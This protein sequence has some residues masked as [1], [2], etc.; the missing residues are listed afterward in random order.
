MGVM[1]NLKRIKALE[2]GG[3]SGGSA[4]SESTIVTNGITE[5]AINFVDK[6]SDFTQKPF[7][8][9]D[10]HIMTFSAVGLFS[11]TGVEV[12]DS[13]LQLA[14]HTDA[15]LKAKVTHILM[16]RINYTENNEE[17]SMIAAFIHSGNEISL[18]DSIKLANPIK[19]QE[20]NFDSSPWFLT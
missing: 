6:T 4:S 11:S 15:S 12:A 1:N 8:I 17:K 3:G 2:A 13:Y 10:G 9:G 19:I 18:K 16:G 5:V 20:I 14:I 7:L